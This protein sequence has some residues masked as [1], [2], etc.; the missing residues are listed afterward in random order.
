MAPLAAA[1]VLL[2]SL[3]ISPS[4]AHAAQQPKVSVDV[5]NQ[6]GQPAQWID[7]AFQRGQNGITYSSGNAPDGRMTVQADAGSQ[8]TYSA[9]GGWLPADQLQARDDCTAQ[10]LAQWTPASVT[11]NV[12]AD[13]S[14]NHAVLQLP[15]MT[16]ELTSPAVNAEEQQMLALINAERVSNGLKPVKLF[17]RAS[18]ASDAHATALATV[19][20]IDAH[21]GPACAGFAAIYSELGGVL[22]NYMDDLGDIVTYRPVCDDSYDAQTAFNRFKNSPLHET[23]MNDY[24]AQAVGI[25]LVDNAWVVNFIGKNDLHSTD[26]VTE[27]TR[28]ALPSLPRSSQSKWCDASDEPTTPGD[29]ADQPTVKPPVRKLTVSSKPARAIKRG[30]TITLRGAA[31]TGRSIKIKAGGK[32]RTVKAKSGQWSLKFKTRKA[33]KAKRIKVTV[34]DGHTSVKLTVRLKR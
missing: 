4:Q 14:L 1:V 16:R 22:N 7:V 24:R 33:S 26:Y 17:E 12:S 25:A 28:Y 34:S 19:N 27:Q 31:T 9:T 6:F 11:I 15:A 13:E 2:F 21:M 8:V 23:A 32:T 20:G 5:L 10:A 3:C 29:G 30:R 18:A